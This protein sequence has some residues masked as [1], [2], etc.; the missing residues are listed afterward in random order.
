M[1]NKA[2]EYQNSKL[3]NF[4]GYNFLGYNTL[5][6]KYFLIFIAHLLFSASCFAVE[7]IKFESNKPNIKILD[8]SNVPDSIIFYN[9]KEEKFSL[10]QFEGKTILLVF[11]ATWCP[12]CVKEMPDLD[13]L[14]KDFRKLAFEVI[15]VS[16][17]YTGIKTVQDYYKNY[18][19][20]YLPIFHDYQ[21]QL[22]KAFSIVGLPTSILIDAD[23][24]KLIAFVGEI[25]WY[26][27]E[28][29]NIILSHIAGNNFLPK[30][31]YRD[32]PLNQSVKPFKEIQ[33]VVPL[34]SPQIEKKIEDNKDQQQNIIAPE[35][36]SSK[37]ENN[38]KKDS[39]AND[40]STK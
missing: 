38:N 27:E 13:I 30:N 32:Q 25:N 31:S 28:I 24:K 7:P 10:D 3:Q 16:Q 26:D 29:R 34:I 21:N 17:D 2:L 18:D 35:V 11:W 36:S 39:T 14:Q 15:P 22:F 33:P 4:L 23:G 8:G 20:R 37:I 40:Q 5:F 9:E 1:N 19:I 6:Y 12:S